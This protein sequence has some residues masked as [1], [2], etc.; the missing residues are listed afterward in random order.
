MRRAYSL[1]VILAI[2]L[3]T[4]TCIHFMSTFFSRGTSVEATES[5]DPRTTWDGLIINHLVD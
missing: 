2:I 3:S 1:L 4:F 5:H